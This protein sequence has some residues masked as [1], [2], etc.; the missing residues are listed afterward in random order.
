MVMMI[1]IIIFIFIIALVII[2]TI[3][4]FERK[5]LKS[6]WRQNSAGNNVSNIESKSKKWRKRKTKN[7]NNYCHG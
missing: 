6:S 1:M 4:V 5:T 2:L 7:D 3:A